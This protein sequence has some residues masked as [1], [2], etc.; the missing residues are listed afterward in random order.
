MSRLAESR[1]Y[2]SPSI[3]ARLALLPSLLILFPTRTKIAGLGLSDYRDY[4]VYLS[5]R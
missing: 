5:S 4:L 3:S 1:T 2:L